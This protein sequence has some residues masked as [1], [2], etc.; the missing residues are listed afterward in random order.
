M[1]ILKGLFLSFIFLTTFLVAG[2]L[3][4]QTW[5]TANQITIAWDPVTVL[6]NGNPIPA[7][8]SIAY[9]VFLKNAVTGEETYVGNTAATQYLI[10]LQDGDKYFSG[11]LTARNIQDTSDVIRSAISWSYDPNVCL[12]NEAF[13]IMYY[14]PPGIVGGL[15]PQ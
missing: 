11:V 8:D 14:I 12:N 1:K 9:E 3:F 13:G 10:S 6:A 7:G 2:S 5:H 4:G 15:R